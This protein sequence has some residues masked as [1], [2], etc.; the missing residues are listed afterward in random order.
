MASLFDKLKN[1]IFPSSNEKTLAPTVE[2]AVDKIMPSLS[3]YDRTKIANMNEERLILYHQNYG[4]FI[5]N[6]FRLWSNVPLKKSCCE[7]SSLSKVNPDQ[8]SYIILK[9]LQ[10][11]IKQ[12]DDLHGDQ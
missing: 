11:R 6:E 8:A 10:S 4:I 5:R 12:A 1:L 3:V 7:I 2:L 9:V